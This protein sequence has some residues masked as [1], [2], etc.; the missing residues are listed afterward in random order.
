MGEREKWTGK[1]VG[2]YH[3]KN[4][5]M[6]ICLVNKKRMLYN[7]TVDTTRSKTSIIHRQL[8]LTLPLSLSSIGTLAVGPIL[9][10][11][12]LQP[13]IN[14]VFTSQLGLL[15]PILHHHVPPSLVTSTVWLLVW[16]NQQILQ[17]STEHILVLQV[18]PLQLWWLDLLYN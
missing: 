18:N 3:R 4:T 9:R 2:M 13:A 1:K 8:N 12:L 15:T 16:G 11:H 14:L 5:R 6:R 7:A 17:G 10:P